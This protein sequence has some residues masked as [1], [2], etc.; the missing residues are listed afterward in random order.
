MMSRVIDYIK[1]I[2]YEL[3]VSEE[4][5]NFTPLDLDSELFPLSVPTDMLFPVGNLEMDDIRKKTN[6]EDSAEK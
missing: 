5:P 3:H 4:I 1:N 6:P 2:N